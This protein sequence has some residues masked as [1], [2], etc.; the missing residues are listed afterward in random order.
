MN[1]INTIIVDDELEA[2]EGI[3]LL[4]EEQEDIN[5]I[6]LCKNGIEAIDMINEHHIDL[7]FL[8]IQMPQVNG[9]EVVRS[10]NKTPMP[11]I[12][13]VTA[14]DQFAIKAF[15]VN[16]VDYLLKPFSNARF[17]EALTRARKL[18]E[19]QRNEEAKARL[20]QVARQALQRSDMEELQVVDG[21]NSGNNRL[22]IKEKGSVKFIPPRIVERDSPEGESLSC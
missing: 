16:A 5:V 11:L 8:D 2:R 22:V 21:D 9:F 10:I 14:Y 6:G 12:V 4:L 19:Q 13:F 3:K 7:V 17:E 1:K 15:E 18:I 20:D